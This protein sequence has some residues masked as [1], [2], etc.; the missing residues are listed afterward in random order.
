MDKTMTTVFWIKVIDSVYECP[1]GNWCG[2]R[3]E[4]PTRCGIG[5]YNP[6]TGDQSEDDCL[7]CPAEKY[8]DGTGDAT[9]FNGDV[10]DGNFSLGGPTSA[11]PDDFIDPATGNLIRSQFLAGYE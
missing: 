2:P 7:P 11:R 5:T 4:A 1:A 3:A 8:Y 6:Y 10:Q 9:N